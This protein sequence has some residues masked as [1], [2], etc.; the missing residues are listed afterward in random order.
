MKKL[1]LLHKAIGSNKQ[2]KPIISLNS[3]YEVYSFD[4]NG[5]SIEKVNMQWLADEIKKFASCNLFFPRPR[6]VFSNG[7]H[8]Y[9]FCFCCI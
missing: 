4:F 3:D 1:S 5:H 8:N 9:F 6:I 2:L 7:F